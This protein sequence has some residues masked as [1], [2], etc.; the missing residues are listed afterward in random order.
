MRR[1]LSF[2]KMWSFGLVLLLVYLGVFSFWLVASVRWIS[3]SSIA[4]TI[5]LLA[6]LLESIRR[7]YFFNRWEILLHLVVVLD[8]LLEGTL[9]RE[10]QS[11]GF[12]FCAL[13]FAGVIAAY[14]IYL[15]RRCS[16][17]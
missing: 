10:H 6:L 11:H 4:V 7:R 2:F 3:L 1:P 13:G 14:R 5:L 15:S 16:S 17:V 9:L 12:Y 8:I